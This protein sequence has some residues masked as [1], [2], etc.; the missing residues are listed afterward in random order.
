MKT[1]TYYGTTF[2]QRKEGIT[3]VLFICSAEDITEWGGVPR[4]SA[5]FMSG[6]QRALDTEHRKDVSDF[7]S[8]DEK[9]ISPTSV[10]VAFKPNSLK[11]ENITSEEFKANPDSLGNPVKI[12]VE[13]ADLESKSIKQLATDVSQKL[14]LY[15][16]NENN[17]EDDEASENSIEQTTDEEGLSIGKSHLKSFLD[18]LENETW[19]NDCINTD[20]EKFRSFLTD[21]LKPATIVDGQHRTY[22]AAHLEERVPFPVV[23]LVDT[24]WKEEVFQF[25]VINQKSVPIK[26]EFLSSIISSS[27]S[28]SDIEDLTDRL[29]QADVNLLNPKIIDLVQTNKKSPFYQ[30]I[31]F[32]IEGERGYLSYS[33]MLTLS[34]RFRGLLTS[35]IHIKANTIQ[36]EIFNKTSKKT[37]FKD[38]KE[39][40]KEK[41]WFEYF[42]EFWS[43][44]YNH[45]DELGYSNLWT[46]GS[47]LLKIVTLQELQNIFLEWLSNRGDEVK[48]TK[49][50]NKLVVKFLKNFKGKFFD[51][52]WKLT[53]LQSKT[54]RDHLRVALRNAQRD[55]EYNSKS[56]LL[57]RGVQEN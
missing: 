30:M 24:D 52:E 6:F 47:N 44:V 57:F 56:D 20:E 36:R 22:G 18:N 55:S 41:L 25:V 51:N 28:N 32:G 46:K 37:K 13:I 48:D 1:Y 19:L 15:I 38:R 7:F 11:I 34:K 4:K 10:V 42:C 35:D 12:T 16:G 53:S 49:T 40:W 29:E 31:D 26:G 54:G 3:S 21:L 14:R 50:M 23:A 5:D 39:E 27:L 43:S 8:K 17:E 9:N 33:G 45:F 2:K